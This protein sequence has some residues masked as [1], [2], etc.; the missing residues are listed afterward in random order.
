MAATELHTALPTVR[1]PPLLSPALSPLP[2]ST[3]THHPHRPAS[4]QTLGHREPRSASPSPSPLVLAGKAPSLAELD[5]PPLRPGLSQG[6]HLR[7]LQEHGF[8]VNLP[9]GQSA[10]STLCP[11]AEASGSPPPMPRGLACAPLPGPPAGVRFLTW[12]SWVVAAAEAEL[13][14]RTPRL[15]PRQQLPRSPRVQSQILPAPL[16]RDLSPPHLV[17]LGRSCGPGIKGWARRPL[18]PSFSLRPRPRPLESVGPPVRTNQ[19]PFVG[20]VGA[21]ELG[22]WTLAS[23]HFTKFPG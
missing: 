1:L 10:L 19:S 11:G 22:S 17:S 14:P 16:S 8:L 3:A 2:S 4:S 5:L 21:T 6:R 18:S 9:A 15:V 20:Y 13:S 7:L 12:T 23:E